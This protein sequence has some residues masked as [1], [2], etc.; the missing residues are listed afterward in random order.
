MSTLDISFVI[1]LF[2]HVEESKAMLASLQKTIPRTIQ[3]EVIL[4]DDCSADETSQWLKSIDEPNI[5]IHINRNNLGYAKTNNLGATLASGK[6]LF[7][8][9][10]DLLFE[11]G[12]LES[13]LACIKTT[14]L[15][16]GIVGNVQYR[17]IDNNIDHAGIELTDL[18]KIEHIKEIDTQNNYKKVFAT[19]GACMLIAREDFTSLGGFDETY[20]N[21]VEDVDLCMRMKQL[22]KPIYVVQNSHIYHHVSLSRDRESIKN[23]MNSQYFYQKWR[24]EIKSELSKRWAKTLS[25]GEVDAANPS[26]DGVLH[27]NF[28]KSPQIASRILAEHFISREEARWKGLIDK[29]DLNEGFPSKC[30]IRGMR[31]SEPHRCYLVSSIFEF[32]VKDVDSVINFFVCGRRID[33]TEKQNIAVI[34]DVNGIQLKRINLSDD[35]NI[36]V[37][38]IS[39]IFIK[40]IINIF[41]ISFKFFDLETNNLLGDANNSV[42]IGHFVLNDIELHD[43]R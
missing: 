25:L 42:V 39:P 26:I 34:I 36:N 38:V 3:Y 41:K 18:G 2:N 13:M 17:V 21:G 32:H 4:V 19:T 40:G 16:A 43:L 15:N 24:T 9:N 6:Y 12:W 8:I 11:D 33:P 10:N 30:S 1:P 31:Y 27:H 20:V 23:E 35:V 28:L 37:G 14:T 7:L 5:K 22:G 29:I